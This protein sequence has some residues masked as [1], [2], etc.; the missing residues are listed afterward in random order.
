[1]N[2][3]LIL[4]LASLV[5][6]GIRGTAQTPGTK[7]W[8]FPTGGGIRSSP[9]LGW[10]GTVYVGS[11]DHSLYA[12]N[13]DGTKKWSY[14]T[15]DSIQSSPAIGRNGTIYVG[16]EDHNLYA[17]NPEDGTKKWQYEAGGKI[18]C[19]PAIGPD[20][21]TYIGSA[22]ERLHAIDRDGFLL[23]YFDA[24]ADVSNSPTV[25][26]NDRIY[27]AAGTNIFALNFQGTMQWKFTTAGICN[28]SAAIAADGT[29]YIGCTDNKLYALTSAGAKKWEFLT[30]NDVDASPS[31]G[32]DGIIY[33]GSLDNYLYAVR[34]NSF[35]KWKFP[36]DNDV[37]SSAAIAADGTV[38]FGSKNHF[39]YAVGEDAVLNWSYRTGGE[40]ES[41]PVIGTNGVVYAGSNDGSLY[42]I[43]G[44][45]GLASTAW[46]MF[47]HD[48][49]HSGVLMA[50]NRE[51][52]LTRIENQSVAEGTLLR[53]TVVGSDADGDSLAYT[54]DP[55]A[56]QGATIGRTNGVFNWTPTEEQGPGNYNVTVRLTDNG[57]PS[58]YD[59]RSFRVDVL[60]TNGAP[61]IPVQG[62]S[63][64]KVD[65]DMRLSW[66]ALSGSSYKVQ[67]KTNL[68]EAVWNDLG[69]LITPGVTP[70]NPMATTRDEILD[71]I[72]RRFY[73]ILVIPP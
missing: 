36:I 53:F 10:D 4:L 11:D 13:P 51:P 20:G 34:T 14:E 60:E 22:D 43:Q 64:L 18:T 54:L 57:I 49:S 5:F 68:T 17:V 67:F 7:L 37:R 30:G 59:F 32:A 12:I 55:G 1:M 15:G 61:V 62:T 2:R 28:S 44:S 26:T 9:A 42:A 69:G 3:T 25:I 31:I 52:V 50:T 48:P 45:S 70:A 24:G 8:S 35:Q 63:I 47:Q 41:S 46:P 21:V 16:S 23:W 58:L 66:N 33:F 19:T 72:P 73:R 6:T 29:I 40:I 65:G 38:C 71:T 39:V 27:F 56:P